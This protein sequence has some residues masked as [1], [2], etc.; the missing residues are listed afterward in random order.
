MENEL[1]SLRCQD[2]HNAVSANVDP[3]SGYLTDYTATRTIGMAGQVI[4]TL[5]GMDV[6]DYQRFEPIAAHQYG[7]DVMWLKQV[8]NVLE[9]CGLVQL[10]GKKNKPEK[11]Y[12]KS[13]YLKSNYETLSEYLT[14]EM[15]PEEIELGTIDILQELSTAPLTTEDVKE[16]YNLDEEQ[17][18]R[19]MYFGRESQ[20]LQFT[21]IEDNIHLISTPM[22][23]DENAISAHA[24]I[25]QFSS[26]EFK[27]AMT[28]IKV[29][30]GFP[31]EISKNPVMQALVAKAI[32]PTPVVR[33][34]G[35]DHPFLF[36]P[37]NTDPSEKIILEKAR[38]IVACVR[39]GENFAKYPITNPVYILNALMDSTI[40]YR[41]RS[42]TVAKE[43]YFLLASKGIGALD[44]T[45]GNWYS[46]R[47]I[48]TEANIRAVKLAKELILY[49]EKV[50]GG[51][52]NDDEI[53]RFI[54]TQGQSVS[55]FKSIKEANKKKDVTPEMA[56]ELLNVIQ[57]VYTFKGRK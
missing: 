36:T 19:L 48:D 27:E 39:T 38:D 49:G 30:Q 41:L 40:G 50:E 43:Q 42:T 51:K 10:M 47:L 2:L 45:G 14:E 3:T 21:T 28:K 53:K 15:S 52:E 26:V 29:Y 8:F 9:D 31:V 22:Y 32:L 57:G 13:K 55:A 56:T 33:M 54:G 23:W 24:I 7:V 4:S 44:S 18:R 6:V 5:H 25:E 11:I 35:I 46:F 1:Y 34:E 17:L 20:L 16:R 12:I 37:Y